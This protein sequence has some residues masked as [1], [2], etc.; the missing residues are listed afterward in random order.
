MFFSVRSF[1]V[2]ISIYMHVYT[3]VGGKAAYCSY[4]QVMCLIEF[5]S[6]ILITLYALVIPRNE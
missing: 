2:S 4:F 3:L 5:V 6:R 1:L